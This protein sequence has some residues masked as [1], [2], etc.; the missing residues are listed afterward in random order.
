MEQ[1]TVIMQDIFLFVKD[2]VDEN[3]KTFGHFESTGVRP[4]CMSRLE[5][6][7]IKLPNNLFAGRVLGGR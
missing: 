1:E 4:H 6:A 2:G 3:G 5:S 7:G